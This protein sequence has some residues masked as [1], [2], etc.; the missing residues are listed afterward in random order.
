[1]EQTQNQ[2]GKILVR[3]TA[4][5]YV[6][7]SRG[8][9]WFFVAAIFTALLVFYAMQTRSWTMAVGFIVLAGV[10]YLSNHHDPQK[11]EVIIT[12]FGI[13]VGGRKI[14]FN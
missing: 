10:Y 11:I 5:E 1:M 7:H 12:D 3:W 4:Q 14:P 6:K 9:V 2:H 13:Q 8:K